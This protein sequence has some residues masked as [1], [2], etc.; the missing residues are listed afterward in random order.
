VGPDDHHLWLGVNT[1][2]GWSLDS[3]VL[4]RVDQDGLSS[5]VPTRLVPSPWASH[6]TIV[7]MASNGP[8]STLPVWPAGDYRLELRVS[9]GDIRRTLEIL[10]LTKPDPAGGEPSPQR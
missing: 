3:A 5:I 1:P 6:F 7:A 9:P 8:D 10:V 2:R 4:R